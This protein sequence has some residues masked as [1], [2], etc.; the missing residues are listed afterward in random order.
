[1]VLLGATVGLASAAD[2]AETKRP[3]RIPDWSGVWVNRGSISF[4]P[5][6]PRAQPANP[7]YNAEY[8]AKYKERLAALARGE[9]IADPTADCVLPGT[10]RN[11]NMPY[12]FEILHTPGRVTL[13][14]ESMH[15]VRRIFTDG[16]KHPS[17]LEPTYNG[18]SIGHWEGDV[19]VVDTVG[20]RADTVFDQVGTFHSDQMRVIE[21]FREISP[22]TLQVEITVED[23][24]AFVRPW[25]VVKTYT[26][27][28]N[29]EI[30]E[31]VC[32]ENNRN[33]I[34]ASGKTSVILG[35]KPDSRPKP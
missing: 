4:D 29:E 30:M 25:K 11:M 16:R 20:L 10:P 6:V 5:S 34:D 18:H 28:P 8:A 27:D 19:L 15:D 32:E 24:K 12:P 35:S 31:Y 3:A 9:A 21:R 17:D 14:M 7:P 26:R 33:P 23:P 22:G 2:K 13:L 1:M